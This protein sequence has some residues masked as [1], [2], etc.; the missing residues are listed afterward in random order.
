MILLIHLIIL[1]VNL[2]MAEK[3][4]RSKFIWFVLTLFLGVLAT[5]ALICLGEVKEVEEEEVED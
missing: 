1:A 4:K 3:R 5:I 2:S